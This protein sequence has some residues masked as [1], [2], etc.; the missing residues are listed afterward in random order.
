MGRWAPKTGQVEYENVASSA[1]SQKINKTI[2]LVSNPLP[3]QPTEPN[4]PRAR[5]S[6]TCFP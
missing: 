1:C 2:Q 5:V 6:S 4:I 3:R